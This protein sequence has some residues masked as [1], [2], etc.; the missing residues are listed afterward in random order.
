MTRNRLVLLAA[1]GSAAL[2]LAAWGFQYLG[3]MAP[4]KL[5]IW[6]RYPHGAAVLIGAVTLATGWRILPWAGALAALTTAGIGLY[7]AGVEQGWWEGPTTCTS[8][9][10][11]GLSAEQLMAQI[12]EA[13]LVRC[14]E[15]PWDLFGIS[16]AGWNGLVSLG[17]ALVW[18]LAATRRA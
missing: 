7:H 14:D 4:C 16:M 2:L 3:G 9:P 11:G 17:L 1:G 18:L 15:I 8:G 6:Q 12:M 10:I 13:P 5:C